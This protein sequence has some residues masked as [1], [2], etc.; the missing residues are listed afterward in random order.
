[1]TKYFYAVTI[2]FVS[3]FISTDTFA[4]HGQGAD[5]T[6][7][8]LG[9][10]Q[11]RIIYQFYRDCSGISASTSVTASIVSSCGGT[12]T[13]TLTQDSLPI[14]VS[15]LCSTSSSTCAGGTLPGVQRYSY[16]AIITLPP[17]CIYTVSYGE[18]CRNTSNNLA[19]SQSFDLYVEAT[20]NTNNSLCNNGPRFTSYPVPYYCIGQTY[21]YSHGTVELDGDSL[22][23]TLVAPLDF[24]NTPIT[25]T[26][27]YS[28]TNPMPTG[29]GFVFDPLT[30][31]MTFRPTTVGNYV[32]AVRVDEYRNGVL[33]G[34]TLR[35]IQIVVIN[36]NNIPP[37]VA[38][39]I[40]T[41]NSSGGTVIDNN[42]LGVCPGGNVTFTI[43]AYDPTGQT[44]NF[45]SNISQSIPGATLTRTPING[46]QDSI[47][48]TFT[49]SPSA[50]DSGFR[51]FTL[52]VTDGNCPIPGN[53]IF[54]YDIT[55]LKGVTLGPDR[56]YCPVGGPIVV[57][58]TGANTFSW[59]TL[60][61][62]PPVGMISSN[63]DS[64]VVSFAPT[65][66][67]TY[68][69]K[70]NLIGGCK[71]SDTITIR[72]V[73]DFSSTIRTSRDTVCKYGTALI[74]SS[75]F[76]DSVG[77]YTYT[78][79]PMSAI[80]LVQDSVATVAPLT[81]TTF[82]VGVT[83]K[84]GCYLRKDSAKIVVSGIGPKVNITADKNYICPGDTIQ[85]TPKIQNLE[86][87]LTPGGL[88]AACLGG[89]QFAFDTI[90]RGTGTS[91]TSTPYRNLWEDGR[92]Q[93][94]I[95]AAELQAQGMQAGTI[96]D[97][98]LFVTTKN[99]SQPFNGFTIKMGCTGLSALS[100]SAGFVNG[101][102]IVANPIPYTTVANS[103]NTH[104]F[105]NPY[106]WDGSSNLI[107]EVCFDNTSYGGTNDAV[108]FTTAFAGATLYR[109]TDGAVGCNL[110]TPTAST[111]RPNFLFGS[112]IPPLTGYTYTWTPTNDLTCT[113]CP[114]PRV[115]LKSNTT[116]KLTVND[117]NCSGDSVI[118]LFI[119]PNVQVSAG[120]DTV[121]CGTPATIKV[122]PLN[123]ATPVCI[124]NYSLATIPYS[125]KISPTPTTVNFTQNCSTGQTH[126]RFAG[127]IT[128]PFPFQ[129]Y[130]NSYNDIY[131]TQNG[132]VTFNPATCTGTPQ[133]LPNAAT[134]NNM[135]ALCYADLGTAGFTGGGGSVEYSTS[136]VAPNRIFTVK[137]NNVQFAYTTSVINGEIQLYE[138]TN[139]VEV[140]TF[141]QNR[142][143]A[144]KVQG[145]ENST[146]TLAVTVPGRNNQVWSVATPE[147]YRF[148][149]QYNGSFVTNVA[150]TPSLGLSDTSIANPIANPATNTC[151]QA[152][153]TYNDDC[154]VRDTVCVNVST[155][156]YTLT[157]SPDT[158]C[159]GDTAQITMTGPGVSYAWTP[160]NLLSD[161]SISNPK[162]TV[163][164]T[165]KFTVLSAN[166][167][168]CVVRDSIFVPTYPAPVINLP[169]DRS[170]C[171][172]DSFQIAPNGGPY[173]QFEWYS[174]ATGNTVIS[175]APS[176][177]A[178]PGNSYYV[179]VKSANSSCFNYSADTFDLTPFTLTPIVAVGA[180]TICDGDSVVLQANAGLSNYQWSNGTTIVS[181]TQLNV[182]KT[183]GT[184]FY[185]ATDP[186]GCNLRSND[187]IVNVDANPVIAFNTVKNP[188]C[189]G[190]VINL[191][192]GLESGVIYSWTPGGVV[193]S[194]AISQAGTYSVTAD[195]NG[196]IRTATYV[197]NAATP[198]TVTLPADVSTCGCSYNATLTST[199]SA[200]TA[201]TYAWSN[202]DSTAD[203]SVTKSGTYIVT[204][205]DGNQCTASATQRTDVYCLDVHAKATKST[206]NKGDST[207]LSVET[208]N[209]SYVPNLKYVWTP[210]SLLTSPLRMTTGAKP[211]NTTTYTVV[212]TDDLHGCSASDTITI[213]VVV[214]GLY[215]MPTGFT[216]NGDGGNDYFYPFFP[217]GSSATVQVLRVYNRW[218]QLVYS[219]AVS[220]GWD[221]KVAGQKAPYDTYT[222]YIE[223]RIPDANQPSGYTI[224]IV[225]GSFALLY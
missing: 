16:S 130:C 156:P 85:L 173:T 161:S 84:D 95:T 191:N 50:A 170:I 131:I 35:D 12:Q 61:G 204:V 109:Q 202:G 205:T 166:A 39:N 77:P 162:A 165:T 54:T 111:E 3:L 91:T 172:Y 147:A 115:A 127:P 112:C 121:V 216:P 152:V 171:P 181:T 40:T 135:I 212:A 178:K 214:P 82:V 63:I 197:V 6:Y 150:W 140:H 51:Y 136:G 31:Q 89:S 98:S 93:Y 55:V 46:R 149:P 9:N 146:G 76:P 41:G 176:I 97:L 148:K 158:I 18:C 80:S 183:A 187:A 169:G 72:R 17:G 215:R 4:S 34:T 222:Y 60:A 49:W 177:F 209:T 53:Q 203:I 104:T 145:V 19:S 27:P 14:E 138:T 139:N 219:G 94:L 194:I 193:D 195:R 23:F 142:L 213:G 66:T 30:G 201:V 182:V 92:T 211:N 47:L 65:V 179:R 36:C 155:Y 107:V 210:D 22:Y 24:N 43:S 117:G 100:A 221:G 106:D 69:A 141:L 114:N 137:Y 21:N 7:E 10:G 103:W 42:S 116:Y 175:T 164:N 71:S 157:L 87:G 198:P 64:T 120:K 102:Q 134:P 59:T 33:I 223:I 78:W 123:P 200:T 154:V 184:Y 88:G 192:A 90:G 56:A 220:P 163:V 206:V 174:L 96:T 11:Y 15:N 20:I 99:S 143:T 25:Y 8:C 119:N 160:A 81:T 68:V 73:A 189:P 105:D 132:Y 190:D 110:T 186:N 86:C 126:D 225:T 5:I 207:V 167:D 2:F 58:A 108:R 26:A 224:D 218:G 153:V 70:S 113:A 159:P 75:A 185:T 83:S 44:V 79:T 1:M 118:Q 74:T 62:G 13:L 168:G 32:V 101:L 28:P 57:N 151:Y 37:V 188:I 133:T 128:L 199:V 45:N 124:P 129:F 208:I 29:S 38:S 125:A 122:A 144:N 180:G 67:T 217:P 52:T 196:C 48:I